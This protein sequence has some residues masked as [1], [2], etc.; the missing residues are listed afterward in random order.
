[1][2]YNSSGTC[3]QY[4]RATQLPSGFEDNNPTNS[5]TYLIETTG[6]EASQNYIYKVI[7][8]ISGIK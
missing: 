7:A 2:A 3:V 5:F 6:E 8:A 1:M 4:I